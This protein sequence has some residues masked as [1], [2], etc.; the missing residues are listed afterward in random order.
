MLQKP[1]TEGNISLGLKKEIL[2]FIDVVHKG[3][4]F[5]L[6]L[7]I[8]LPVMTILIAGIY[9]LYLQKTNLSQKASPCL[10]IIK[11][12]QSVK[13]IGKNLEKEG[14]VRSASQFVQWMVRFGFDR[15][16]QPGRFMIQK[17][18][19]LFDVIK[20]VSRSSDFMETITVP[21]GLNIRQTAK[22]FAKAGLDEDRFAALCTSKSFIS[23]LK[24]DVPTLEG[25]LF[26]DTYEIVY[27]DDEKKVIHHMI[28]RFYQITAKLALPTST[29]FKTVGFQNGLVIASIIEKESCYYP[30]RPQVSGVFWNRY[31][32]GWRLDSD[33]TVRYA[34]DKWGGELTKS[35]LQYDSPYNTRR[36]KGIPPA[37]ICSPGAN[38]IKASFF[39]DKTDQM[40]FICSGKED[41]SSYFNKQMKDHNKI[42]K[43]LKSE[44]KLKP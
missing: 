17:N 29:I 10:F 8:L 18:F 4:L 25:Y 42:K 35:D 21:E 26:P 13:D 43:K 2:H 7:A 5:I 39:P 19:S 32:K 14:C 38:S 44:G 12:N 6:N 30:E 23:E 31:K 11:E 33:C 22:L 24:L 34:L 3:W 40:Y 15:K 36:Y 28:K 16:M 27:G 37:P 1:S 9:H 41:G 20:K